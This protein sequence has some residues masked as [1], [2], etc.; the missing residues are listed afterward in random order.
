M[1]SF[2]ESM[3]QWATVTGRHFLF[4]FWWI[5]VLAAL[6]TALSESFLIEGRRRRLLEHPAEGWRT[7]RLAALLGVLSPPSRRRIFQQ[8]K[9]MLAGGVML[10]APACR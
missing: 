2:I 1:P 7:V 8:A 10:Q 4:M 3:V 5:W 9:E 6:A